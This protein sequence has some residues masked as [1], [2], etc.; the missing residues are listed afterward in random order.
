MLAMAHLH[1]STEVADIY[2]EESEGWESFIKANHNA[3]EM[4]DWFLGNNSKG[5]KQFPNI[6]PLCA[7]LLLGDL[8]EGKCNFFPMPTPLSWG[9]LVHELDL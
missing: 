6:G 1:K 3:K 7:L 9:D 2:W 4:F 5:K 8:I